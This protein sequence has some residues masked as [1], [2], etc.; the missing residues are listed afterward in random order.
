MTAAPVFF[1]EMGLEQNNVRALYRHIRTMARGNAGRRAGGAPGAG[2]IYVS[3]ESHYFRRLRRQ[4]RRRAAHSLRHH[5]RLISRA[6]WTR[7]E[8][9]LIQRVNALNMFLRDVYGPRAILKEG[10]I[11][12]S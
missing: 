7:L 5:S 12:P 3:P 9:G 8:A 2:R 6:E 10:L 1:D 11:P 4:G